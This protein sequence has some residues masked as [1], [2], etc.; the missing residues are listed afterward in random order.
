MNIFNSSLLFLAVKIEIL[1]ENP[2]KKEKVDIL[3]VVR[4]FFHNNT[5][6][7]FLEIYAFIAIG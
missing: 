5:T 7:N 6:V 1:T 2:V 4:V 3:V